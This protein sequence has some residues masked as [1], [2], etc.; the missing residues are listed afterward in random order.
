MAEKVFQV[1]LTKTNDAGETF[2]KTRIGEIEGS[3]WYQAAEQLIREKG[4][5]EIL[6]ALTQWGMEHN[7]WKEPAVA[8]RKEALHLHVD[9]IFDNPRWV[10]FVPFNRRYRPEVLEQAHLVTVINACCGQPGE[11]TQEQIDG[12][13]GGTIACPCCGKWSHFDIVDSS[14]DI[15]EQQA[16]QMSRMEMT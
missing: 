11:V 7:Y 6:D 14:H 16:E 15:S 1:C 4:E 2:V 13:Y 5:L 8:V 12:A 9:R 10:D 3:V